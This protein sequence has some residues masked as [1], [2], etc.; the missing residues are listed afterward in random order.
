[1]AI[2]E[3]TLADKLRAL[4]PDRLRSV[5]H[6]VGYLLEQQKAELEAQAVAKGWPAGYF[7][8]TAGSIPDFPDVD[9]DM[10]GLDPSL[11]QSD[12]HLRL[13]PPEDTG[14]DGTAR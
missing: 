6:F 11:D 4:T 5:E 14:A 1:M 9:G 2:I 13:D 10:S 7:E 3:Q 8:R 12:D